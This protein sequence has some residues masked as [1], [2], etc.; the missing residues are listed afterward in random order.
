M[1]KSKGSRFSLVVTY[2]HSFA[3]QLVMKIFELL[4]EYQIPPPLVG[5]SLHFIDK[6]QLL[7]LQPEEYWF[8]SG[9][10]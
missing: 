8:H 6:A 4:T 1:E 7:D 9:I 2:F 3:R 5:L 10:P